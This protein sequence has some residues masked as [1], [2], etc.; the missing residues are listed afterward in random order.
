MSELA[1]TDVVGMPTTLSALCTE[2]WGF[3]AYN[4]R[5]VVKGKLIL[6]YAP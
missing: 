5:G 1:C 2:H 6:E 4:R 3:D